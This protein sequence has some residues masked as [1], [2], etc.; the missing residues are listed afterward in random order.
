VQNAS[1]RVKSFTY[2][3][4]QGVRVARLTLNTEDFLKHIEN[5]IQVVLAY[6]ISNLSVTTVGN[7]NTAD[8]NNIILTQCAMSTRFKGLVDDL[9]AGIG[10]A[11]SKRD[12][13]TATAKLK[14]LE[15]IQSE[16][17][18]IIAYFDKSIKSN[19]RQENVQRVYDTD[20]RIKTAYNTNK[21]LVN[22]R[23]TT[24]SDTTT[25]TE[26]MSS[27]KKIRAQMEEDSSD[28]IDK[29]IGSTGFITRQSTKCTEL[30]E[31]C[32]TTKDR[33]D[34]IVDITELTAIK[35]ELKSKSKHIER[36]KLVTDII[37]D[38]LVIE[39]N[40]M[41]F[42]KIK[43]YVDSATTDDDSNIN[44]M[45]VELARIKGVDD[46]GTQLTSCKTKIRTS[47]ANINLHAIP[48]TDDKIAEVVS[49]QD[50]AAKL[51]IIRDW[52]TEGGTKKNK[53][54]EEVE[55]AEKI[56]ENVEKIKNILE[57]PPK[58]DYTTK[59]VGSFN[60]FF[61]LTKHNQKRLKNP[62]TDADI[63]THSATHDSWKKT[64]ELEYEIHKAFVGAGSADPD[65]VYDP[66]KV[67]GE[68]Y[69]SLER[70]SDRIKNMAERELCTWAEGQLED[71]KKE[72]I[73]YSK[74]EQKQK[75]KTDRLSKMITDRSIKHTALL[76]Y[77][78]ST[79]WGTTNPEI[80]TKMKKKEG[81]VV[82]TVINIKDHPL[83]SWQDLC[84]RISY[85]HICLKKNFTGIKSVQIGDA[86][87]REQELIERE[88]KF[89]DCVKYHNQRIDIITFS[90]F[91]IALKGR[92][93]NTMSSGP[94]TNIYTE[95]ID[96]V[97]KFILYVL[98]SNKTTLVAPSV[99]DVIDFDANSDLNSVSYPWKH[100]AS[101]AF[102]ISKLLK[103]KNKEYD[104]ARDY[105][106]NLY[107][108]KLSRAG[109][110]DR[111]A[112]AHY[113]ASRI[114]GFYLIDHGWDYVDLV[115]DPV[116]P[117]V[118]PPSTRTLREVEGLMEIQLESVEKIVELVREKSNLF[119]D[120]ISPAGKPYIHP[121]HYIIYEYEKML[122]EGTILSDS[123]LS[124]ILDGA[125]AN[126]GTE[127]N[128]NPLWNIPPSK[129]IQPNMKFKKHMSTLHPDS[130]GFKPYMLYAI[131]KNMGAH[132]LYKDI[133]FTG[134][135][136]AH[137]VSIYGSVEW[138]H[139]KPIILKPYERV[140][141]SKWGDTI[142]N[143]DIYKKFVKTC[144]ILK[145][146]LAIKE[147]WPIPRADDVNYNLLISKTKKLAKE[148]FTS[149]SDINELNGHVSNIRNSASKEIFDRN[150]TLAYEKAHAMI[151]G[152]IV[153]LRA[154]N[155]VKDIVHPDDTEFID[156]V[157]SAH[158]IHDI[159]KDDFRG[160]ISLIELFRKSPPE[161]GGVLS[162]LVRMGGAPIAYLC[163]NMHVC[164]YIIIIL[165]LL[166]IVINN[167][168]TKPQ[169][170]HRYLESS[171]D[172]CKVAPAAI[173]CESH[174][175]RD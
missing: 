134:E 88:K 68:E 37:H 122:I 27:L 144:S 104:T 151:K 137:I 53:I 108:T 79:K 78:L 12:K 9:V 94:L 114:V 49:M 152:K 3:D 99:I 136:I 139:G 5:L 67:I 34:E 117:V 58:S 93:E 103:N 161:G 153:D 131:L 35:D 106:T 65:K 19:E 20:E 87:R 115:A 23:C 31:D 6:K 92:I 156:F 174:W 169:N 7:T 66:T 64:R 95:R 149:A 119:S 46:Y 33:A 61:H 147:F 90:K 21:S 85:A 22:T 57:E 96:G 32:K 38:N 120:R 40:K 8:L 97:E 150:C 86:D 25:G 121:F 18:K 42:N 129:P 59:E 133:P 141:N 140:E 39:Y 60:W 160:R 77:Y 45:L 167:A 154:D 105:F 157:L 16:H 143:T 48:L 14:E 166:Y 52:K 69:T 113:A 28:L 172:Y 76:M 10:D 56:L 80:I 71:I 82:D 111:E 30:L 50:N 138:I 109:A 159:F 146:I 132:G 165:L 4:H 36:V 175:T 84:S 123:K 116:V 128:L 51:G 54:K 15:K 2:G 75:F 11:I 26:P 13:P 168:P 102:V 163:E 24:D 1:A 74:Y 155:T 142:L 91:V 110:A 63:A 170:T 112:S 72:I 81:S 135:A 55:S 62:P 171:T 145:Y 101:V 124:E 127:V 148:M 126:L 17:E 89:S 44:G 73:K 107:N 43:T 118:Q 98:I 83:S 162:S 100:D 41:L 164:M 130:Q 47:N 158:G 173:D 70:I 29:Y 125:V